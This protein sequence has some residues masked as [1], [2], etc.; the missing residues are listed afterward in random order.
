[1]NHLEIY[2]ATMAHEP[3]DEFLY[4]AGFIGALDRKIR[5]ELGLADDVNLGEY[6]GMWQCAHIGPHI[7]ARKKQVDFSRYYEDMEIPEG[8]YIDGAGVLQIPAGFY[9]FMGMV[10]PLRNAQTLEELEEYPWPELDGWNEDY[11]AEEVRKA[12]EK[13]MPACTWTG[14]MYE[15][16]WQIR[17]LEEFLTDMVARPEF[18][19][20]ILDR[21]A[22]RNLRIAQAAARAGVDFL[23]TGDDVANQEALMFHPDVWRRFL[24]SRWGKVY[25]AAREIK[26]DIDI[27]YHSDGDIYA[28]IPELLEIGVTIFNPIQPECMDIVDVKKKWGDRMVMDGT[29]GTQTTMPFGTADEVRRV[30]AERVRTLGRDGA[31]IISPT[32]V[33]E[34][35]VPVANVVAFFETAHEARKFL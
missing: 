17:G 10:S 16:A 27:W 8:A 25:A 21:L 4:H 1:M 19:A 22:D 3:H 24:K 2:R 28:I 6:F 32:H 29:V 9:H 20:F 13:G 12:H 5:D 7:P 35:E 26:P 30:V 15:E 33:L 18:A 31:L 23:R 11:M 14:H 34:P